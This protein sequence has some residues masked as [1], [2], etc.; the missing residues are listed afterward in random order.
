[1]GGALILESLTLLHWCQKQGY[2]PLGLTGISMGGH[3]STFLLA[4]IIIMIKI[5]ILTFFV[6]C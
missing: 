6:S 1:M 2:G 3:V 5:I 4:L